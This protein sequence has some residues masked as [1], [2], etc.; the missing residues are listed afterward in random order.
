[1]PLFPRPAAGLAPLLFLNIGAFF[2]ISGNM[3][4]RILDPRMY[5]FSNCATLP[6]RYVTVTWVIW[7]F[8][9]SSAS[10]NFPRYTSPV[11]VSQVTT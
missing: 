6:S 11:F 4:N 7:L 5:T 2:N 10:I 9:L 3:R 1:M 8:I